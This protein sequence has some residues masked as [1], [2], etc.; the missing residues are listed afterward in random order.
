MEIQQEIC[1]WFQQNHRPLEFRINKNPYS[2]WVSEIMAQQTR[3]DSMLPYYRR[4]MKDYPTIE[5]LAQAPL[6]QVLK[7]WEGL[8][9]YNR[10]RKLKQGAIEVMERF[11]GQL[12]QTAQELETISGIGPY[13]AGAIASIAFNQESPAVD[14]NVLRVIARLLMLEEDI[15]KQKTQKLVRSIVQEMMKGSCPS[16]F[17]Q[18]LMELGALVCMPKIILCEQCPLQHKCLSYRYQK[19]HEF[20]IKSKA[21]K[22]IELHFQT[23]IIEK[24]NQILLSQ[25]DQDGLMKGFYRLPQV[26]NADLSG[27]RLIK[28]AKH[29]YSHR[30][31]TMDVY[32][33]ETGEIPNHELWTWV[34]KQQ[35]KELPMIGAHRKILL[36]L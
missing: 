36:D 20:P 14:G 12:P 32:R 7:S 13:T 3:I 2:I 29:V 23:L 21:K 33:Y 22:P 4:W 5:A 1:S 15:S 8:G 19:Q 34:D 27:F 24:D 26:N 9:Y 16:D 25:D 17:T 18:G 35:L 31:W 10:A 30:I 11:K 28:K 6:E